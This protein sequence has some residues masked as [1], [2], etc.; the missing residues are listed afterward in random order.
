MDDFDESIGME[1]ESRGSKVGLVAILIGIVGIVVGVTGIFLAN[2]AQGEVKT[3]EARL[4]AQPDKTPELEGAIQDVNARLE[5]LG[6]E[7]VKLGRA[8]RQ[9]QENTQKA[10][11][12]VGK[13]ITDNRKA[14]NEMATKLEEL[15]QKLENYRPPART[16]ASTPSSGGSGGGET[17]TAPGEVTPDG[18]YS[19]QSGD[20]L[21]K[22]A[23]QFGISLSQLLAANPGVDPRR[24]RI[25]Q[26]IV[27]PEP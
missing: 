2:Q 6:T 14:I 20:T 15:V 17:T 5:K 9:L 7:F 10:F 22:I 11:T 16:T 8:D 12:D 24:L 21:S 27:I 1:E 25:G 13:D 26:R 23:S 18:T 19:I 3:L 4:S